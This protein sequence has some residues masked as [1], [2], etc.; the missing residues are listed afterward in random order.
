MRAEDRRHDATVGQ[1]GRL[2]RVLDNDDD[3]VTPLDMLAEL[4]D[5]NKTLAAQACD[6]AERRDLVPVRSSTWRA[7]WTR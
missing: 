4:R 5:D 3:Y 7:R 1:I 6:E 2:Q